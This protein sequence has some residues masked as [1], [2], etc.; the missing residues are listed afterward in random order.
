MVTGNRLPRNAECGDS[1]AR[2]IPLVR[3]SATLPPPS[4]VDAAQKLQVN[5]AQ[6]VGGNLQSASH[7]EVIEGVCNQHDGGPGLGAHT[8]KNGLNLL[9]WKCLG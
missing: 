1:A 6:T 8:L 4:V 3:S 5:A 7:G 9:G 2:K